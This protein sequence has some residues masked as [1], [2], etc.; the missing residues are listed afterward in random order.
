MYHEFGEWWADSI[1][2]YRNAGLTIDYISIQNEC[3]WHASYD[4]MLLGKFENER[5]AEYAKAFLATYQVMQERFGTD[6]PLMLGPETMTFR[7]LDLKVYMSNIIDVLPESI[8]GIAYHLY[9][10][11]DSAGEGGEGAG[12]GRSTNEPDTFNQNFIDNYLEFGGRFPIWQTE[13][14]R[15]TPMQTAVLMHNALVNGNVNAYLHWTGVWERSFPSHDL[16]GVNRRGEVSVGSSF[17]VMRHFS[18]FIR[19]GFI[20]VQVNVPF[21]SAYRISAFKSPDESKLAVVLI[22]PTDENLEVALP[23]ENFSIIESV[24]Y[25]TVLEADSYEAEDYYVNT[26]TLGQGNTVL[27]KAHS[28]TTIDITGEMN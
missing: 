1:E 5:V 23:I 12:P 6:A 7:S 20:R 11:G 2:A 15:G 19:P 25:Q 4:G 14:Y 26:G 21:N 24:I 13:F 9:I 3:D 16:I 18:E 28:I 17:Y 8:A 22:N 27:L 10:G